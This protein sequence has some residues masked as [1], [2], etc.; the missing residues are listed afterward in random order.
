L[1]YKLFIYLLYNNTIP[2]GKSKYK[3]EVLTIFMITAL[4]GNL[5]IEGYNNG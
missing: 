2:L 1:N 4:Y 3:N 5:L